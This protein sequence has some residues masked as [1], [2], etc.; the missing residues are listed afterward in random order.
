MPPEV[1]PARG[2][3]HAG[4]QLQWA[5]QRLRFLPLPAR[6]AAS[7]IARSSS[8]VCLLKGCPDGTP[9]HV[10]NNPG[11]FVTT[12]AGIGGALDGGGRSAGRGRG[13]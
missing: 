6:A 2:K 4:E 8:A 3:R 5:C 13:E 7:R 11:S 12:P 9:P 10:R 1:W